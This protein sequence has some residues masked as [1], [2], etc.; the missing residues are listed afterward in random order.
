MT[1]L[2]AI[3]LAGIT[4]A[5]AVSSCVLAV[6]CI[7]QPDPWL[8]L[9]IA[10]QKDQIDSLDCFVSAAM[11]N[12]ADPTDLKEQTPLH[13]AANFN[14]PRVI[15]YL[16]Q[17]GALIDNKNFLDKTPLVQAI[18]S[19]SDDAA[20]VLILNGADLEQADK[21]GRTALF[22]S[23]IYKNVALTNLLSQRGANPDQQVSI[24]SYSPGANRHTTIRVLGKKSK[25]FAIRALFI[26]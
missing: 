14:R 6:E 9:A 3:E 4:F 23:V 21:Q 2:I 1:R 10:I 22:W 11:L 13:L 18:E 26:K 20:A 7:P 16:L 25:I 24:Y 19:G 17:R 5:V 12:G 8:S 15:Y